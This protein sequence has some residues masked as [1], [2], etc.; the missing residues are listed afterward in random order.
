MTQEWTIIVS[1]GVW[2]TESFVKR[3]GLYIERVWICFIT[4]MYNFE[5]LAPPVGTVCS[6]TMRSLENF[7]VNRSHS[8]CMSSSTWV[9]VSSGIVLWN[10]HQF[11]SSCCTLYYRQRLVTYRTCGLPGV[12]LASNITSTRLF[13]VCILFL[14][15]SFF[16]NIVFFRFSTGF[17]LW[18]TFLLFYSSIHFPIFPF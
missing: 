18:L 16:A 10:L 2:H 14:R 13:L 15:S 17:F 4:V 12:K 6:R 5:L 8:S 7:G 3:Y 11:C 1:I 9:A